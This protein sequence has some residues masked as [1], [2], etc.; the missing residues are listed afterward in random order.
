MALPIAGHV[1]GTD[2]VSADCEELDE[3][4]MACLSRFDARAR[5]RR[6]KRVRAGGRDQCQS[7]SRVQ[8]DRDDVRGSRRQGMSA[9][10]SSVLG[11]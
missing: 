10:L 2:N 8:V 7:V 3:L 5:A 9:V 6:T 1:R 11:V 4:G